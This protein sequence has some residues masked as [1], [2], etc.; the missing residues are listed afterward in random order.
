MKL[1]YVC[2]AYEGADSDYKAAVEYG[3]YVKRAGGVPIIPHIMYHGILKD[4]EFEEKEAIICICRSFMELC[5]EVWV[6]GK[7]RTFNVKEEIALARNLG[8]EEKNISPMQTAMANDDL[9]LIVRDY[10]KT[11]GC[12]MNGA[13][14]QDII[15]YLECGISRE[16]ISHVITIQAYKN[17]TW[18]YSKAILERCRAE[19]VKTLDEF[20]R[21]ADKKKSNKASYDL[22]AFEKLI[23]SD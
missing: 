2:S 6:F 5:S 12:P 20:K 4:T 23:N 14:G 10:E 22:D 17:A 1:I 18:N 19:N 15:F 8:I 3:R 11:T 21:K 13:I 9:A 16:V 7:R